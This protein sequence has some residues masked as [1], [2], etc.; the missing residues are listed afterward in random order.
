MK[1]YSLRPKNIKRRWHLIDAAEA[2]LGRVATAAAR[3]LLGKDKVELTPHMDN[4]DYVVVINCDRLVVTGNKKGS[5][6]YYR[7]SGFPGGLRS[8]TLNEQM[9]ID[10]TKI[11]EHAVRGMLPVNKLRDGRLKRLKTYKG[12]DHSHAA[13]KPSVISLASKE[14]K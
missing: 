7:H 1:T 3:L 6:I 4:G 14:N 9:E 5:K 2:P 10:S 8:R 11:I 13:Q 12:A